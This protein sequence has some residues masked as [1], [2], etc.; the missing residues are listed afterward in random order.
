[1]HFEF[2][3]PWFLL[4]MFLAPVAFVLARRVRSTLQFSSLETADQAPVSWRT[5]L[6]L[7][8]PL[9]STM[10]VV[11]LAIA[12]A[13]PRTPDEETK[14]HREG[15]AVMMVIDRSGSMEARD[16]VR[17]DNSVNRLDTVKLVFEQ[18]V[19]GDGESGRGRPDD[20]IGL[21][22]FASFADS[23]CPLT[24]D[25]GNLVAMSQQIEIASAASGE[26][27]TAVGEGLALA[28]ERLRQHQAK[29]K[30][31][32]LL[33]DGV[34]NAGEIDPD[35]AADLALE[36]GIRVYCIGVGTNGVAPI[37]V[38]DRFNRVRMAAMRVEIDEESLREIVHQTGGQY[39]RATNAQAL[40]GIYAEI[41]QLERT[42]ISEVRYLEYTEHY[43]G[44]VSAAL[45]LLALGAIANSS[46][47]RQL[48]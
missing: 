46:V 25:H 27:G 26:D 14:D 1:M 17:G 35:Q 42:K 18:F 23:L 13:G 39:F 38:T 10:A 31:I 8:P 22:S 7:V 16:M 36:H 41:D 11:L 47:L 48:P 37:P 15:I 3:D 34:N 12:L 32:I 44:F 43:G 28:V 21:I 24:L 4:A 19:L 5:R 6:L 33:T 9:L 20:M 40:E 45:G 30:V 29:S 2:R